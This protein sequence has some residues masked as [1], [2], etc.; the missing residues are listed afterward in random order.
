MRP[1]GTGAH[2][3]DALAARVADVRDVAGAAGALAVGDPTLQPADLDG[4]VHRLQGLADGAGSLALGLLRADA[5]ADRGQEVGSLDY[6]GGALEIALPYLRDE[7]GDVDADG[8]ALDAGRVLAVEAALGLDSR[9]GLA[10]ALGYLEHVA[11][12]LRAVLAGHVLRRQ[13]EPFPDRGLAALRPQGG[14]ACEGF[15]RQVIESLL[16]EGYL[17]IAHCGS[18]ARASAMWHL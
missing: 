3:R 6:A 7:A 2:D 8:A 5:P 14:K 17:G 16:R 15:L 18:P 4:L 13:G 9:L 1:G 11:R 10:V 12:A